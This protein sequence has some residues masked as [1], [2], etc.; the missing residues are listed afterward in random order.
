MAATP[1]LRHT[2]Y[3]CLTHVELPLQFPSYVTPVYM[4]E[5]QAPGG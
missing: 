4:G 2:F 5:A 1:P 3:A